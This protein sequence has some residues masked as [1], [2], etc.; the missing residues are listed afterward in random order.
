MTYAQRI[1][2]KNRDID[3]DSII[4]DAEHKIVA[5]TGIRRS[6]KSSILMLLL[7]RL[8]EKNQ[9]AVYVNAEDTR[10]RNTPDILDEAL[11]WFGEGYLL[12]DEVTNTQKRISY[13]SELMGTQLV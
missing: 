4:K 13:H 8:N 2:L 5:L 1:R 7:Q 9:K 6:G 11:R 12:I 10:L 3:L